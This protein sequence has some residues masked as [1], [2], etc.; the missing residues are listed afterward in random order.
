MAGPRR[1]TPTRRRKRRPA[2]HPGRWVVPTLAV[3]GGLLVAAT[4]VAPTVLEV[5]TTSRG[6]AVGAQLNVDSPV[7]TDPFTAAVTS[8]GLAH[9]GSAAARQADTGLVV[10]QPPRPHRI[11]VMPNANVG[12]PPELT[13][14][15]DP[16]GGFTTPRRMDPGV[17]PGPGSATVSWMTANRPEVL[18][19]RVSAVSQVLVPG[20]QADPV[21]LQVPAAEG[22]QEQ[23]VVLPGLTPGVP[24]VFWLE[25]ETLSPSTGVARLFQV[26][27]SA[28]VVIG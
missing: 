15:P 10:P 8:E 7:G 3:A 14:R 24:Y 27:T 19:Y 22:C 28:P 25:E 12:E 13:P 2:R 9:A 21:R 4:Q 23:A 26:G 20:E 16:C 11:V 5:T 6:V 1:T 18:S 17:V